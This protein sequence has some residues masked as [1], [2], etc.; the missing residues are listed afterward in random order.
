MNDSNNHNIASCKSTWEVVHL[1]AQQIKKMPEYAECEISTYGPFGVSA[2]CSVF[3]NDKK[4]L[5][6]IGSIHVH[7]DHESESGFSYGAAREDRSRINILKEKPL[8]ADIKAA[9]DCL[10]DTKNVAKELL[11]TIN[12]FSDEKCILLHNMTCEVDAH[13]VFNMSGLGKR[14]IRDIEGKEIEATLSENFDKTA[15]YYVADVTNPNVPFYYFEYELR[16]M[17]HF[18]ELHNSSYIKEQYNKTPRE[19]L[20]NNAAYLGYADRVRELA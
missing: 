4:T 6:I 19:M 12:S 9:I 14:T 10:F 11:P 17:H 2:E 15:P 18:D 1:L 16:S 7:Y 8:P 5:D 3:I 20:A 13:K